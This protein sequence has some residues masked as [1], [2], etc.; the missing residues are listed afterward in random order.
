[1]CVFSLTLRYSRQLMRS[2]CTLGCVGCESFS[3]LH[4]LPGSLCCGLFKWLNRSSCRRSLVSATA[5]VPCQRTASS[6][7][8]STAD[9]TK[10][11]KQQQV[12]R[13][14]VSTLCCI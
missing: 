13:L 11:S 4:A 14:C 7:Y 5:L 9:L 12:T 8:H 6:T 1:M 10:I 3:V 2:L